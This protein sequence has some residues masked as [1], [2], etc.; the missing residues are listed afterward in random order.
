MRTI[1][2]L[3]KGLLLVALLASGYAYSAEKTVQV[4]YEQGTPVAQ[5]KLGDSY[6]TLREGQIRCTKAA[7]DR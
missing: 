7:S 3:V 6:C 4:V 2:N 1:E 5:F